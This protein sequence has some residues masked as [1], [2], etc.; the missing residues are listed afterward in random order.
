MTPT[1]LLLLLAGGAAQA[2][3]P[4]AHETALRAQTMDTFGP[5]I[6]PS[7][8]QL[9]E[10]RMKVTDKVVYGYY[11]YWAHDLSTIRWDALTH[12]AWFSVEV[13]SSG[14]AINT[15]GWPDPETVDAAHAANVRVDLAFTLFSGDGI[16]TLVNDPARRAAAITTMIDLMEQG[17]ADGIAIDFEG[18]VDGTRAGFVTFIA[19]LRAGLDAR[20]HQDAEISMAGPA[21][22]WGDEWDVAA[23]LDSADYFFIMGYD[24][25]WSGSGRAGPSGILKMSADYAGV[26]SWTATRS[27]ANYAS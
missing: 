10:G 26:T 27:V 21:V 17:G 23:L 14:A 5:R 4:S 15:H 13:N 8:Q 9:F 2:S 7:E 22:D 6:L 24:Y 25:F 16:K 20:G 12:L 11:P 3:A 18:F 1:A 19:E